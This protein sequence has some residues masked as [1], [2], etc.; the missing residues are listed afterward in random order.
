MTQVMRRVAEILTRKSAALEDRCDSPPRSADYQDFSGQRNSA[1][2]TG[3][4]ALRT[5]YWRAL[6][7]ASVSD[8]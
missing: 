8:R 3:C 1:S 2:N 5:S 7:A 4:N 6:A